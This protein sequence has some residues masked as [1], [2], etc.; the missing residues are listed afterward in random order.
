MLF[1]N[2]IVMTVLDVWKITFFYVAIMWALERLAAKGKISSS[3]QL[4]SLCFWAIMGIGTGAAITL[5]NALGEW[6]QP[7]PLVLLPVRHWLAVPWLHWSMYVVGPLLSVILYDFFDYWMHRAQHKWFW[8]L[9]SIHHS[10]EELSGVNSYFHW[11]EKFFRIL[12]ISLPAAYLVG[13]DG[14]GTVFATELLIGLQGYYLHSPISL[15]VGS[16][17]RRLIA[18]NRFHRIHHSVEPHHFDKNFGAGTTLWDQLFGTAHFPERD[19]WPATGITEQREPRTI[20]DYFWEPFRRPIEQASRDGEAAGL[21]DRF[22]ATQFAE[23]RP[24]LSL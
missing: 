21:D 2:S 4:R 18:D 23:E 12:F 10:I 8:R 13:I 20:A 22:A 9:H 3:S 15:H 5:Y 16:V 14:T 11:T 7:Q 6:L 24:R 17:L 19:E 1:V